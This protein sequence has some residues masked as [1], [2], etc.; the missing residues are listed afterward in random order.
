FQDP[1]V[2]NGVGDGTV[3]IVLKNRMGWVRET[4]RWSCHARWCFPILEGKPVCGKAVRS[5]AGHD[6]CSGQQILVNRP[7]QMRGVDVDVVC[8][9]RK[10]GAEL[11]LDSERCLLRLGAA[12][13]RLPRKQYRAGRPR[14]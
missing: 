12:I 4:E 6:G 9:N 3:L 13:I 2:V 7:G 8:R 5:G 1:A 11:T 14:A 10:A